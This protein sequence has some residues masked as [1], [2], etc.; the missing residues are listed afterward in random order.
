MK[1]IIILPLLLSSSYL[2]AITTGNSTYKKIYQA[3]SKPINENEYYGRSATRFFPTKR[4]EEICREK[5]EKLESKIKKNEKTDPTTLR[6]IN[7][8]GLWTGISIAAGFVNWKYAPYSSANQI[9]ALQ[10]TIT[11]T[12]ILLAMYGGY[13][14]VKNMFTLFRWKK[15]KDKINNYQMRLETHNKVMKWLQGGMI[16]D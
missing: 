16:F 10:Y 8:G 3:F 12:C 6:K 14:S 11:S 2:Y 4:L 13:Y 1:K 5:I 7:V 15:N 9:N